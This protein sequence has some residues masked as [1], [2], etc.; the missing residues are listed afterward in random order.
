[1]SSPANLAR[2]LVEKSLPTFMQ[3]LDS[4]PVKAFTTLLSFLSDKINLRDNQVTIEGNKFAS[5]LQSF[6]A[7]P[8]ASKLS[9]KHVIDA[10]DSIL[11]RWE[12]AGGGGKLPVLILVSS[13][14]WLFVLLV[15][16]RVH[17][18]L[19]VLHCKHYGVY[20][21]IDTVE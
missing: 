21:C 7:G 10:Y 16:S 9:L 1:M 11:D 12:E 17:V 14:W 20:A 5:A 13:Q 8:D 3:Q 2:V 19:H 6:A 18:G 4:L 15:I